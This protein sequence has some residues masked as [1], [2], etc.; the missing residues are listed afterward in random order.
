MKSAP[1]TSFFEGVFALSLPLAV[2]F[3]TFDFWPWTFDP[4]VKESSHTTTQNTASIKFFKCPADALVDTDTMPKYI[5]LVSAAFLTLIAACGDPQN[6]VELEAAADS[7]TFTDALLSVPKKDGVLKNDTLPA[8]YDLSFDEPVYGTLKMK[9]DGSFDYQHDG[10]DTTEDSFS[11]TL[12]AGGVEQSATVTLTKS[13]AEP[14][15]PE[16]PET[17][18]NPDTPSN[19]ETPENPEEPAALCSETAQVGAAYE[20]QLTVGD[21]LKDAP[22]G[23]VLHERSGLLRWT[24]TSDQTKEQEFV[25]VTSDAE[26]NFKLTV[27]AGSENPAGLYVAPDGDDAKAGDAANPFATLQHAVE[28]AEPG[29]TIYVRGGDYYHPEYA[30]P[31]EGRQANVVAKVKKSGEAGKPITLKNYGNEF[32]RII[33]DEGGVLFDKGVQYWVVEGL[34]LQGN[35]G[36][37]DY[38]KRWRCG[39]PTITVLAR[40]VVFATARLRTSRFATTSSMTFPVAAWPTTAQTALRFRTI[41]STIPAGGLPPVRTAS[42]TRS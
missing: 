27:S 13:N 31:F 24:P 30:Q 41:S 35:L 29:Q 11:Y 22:R 8:S 14:V 42:P 15:T 4:N 2:R 18:D 23:M 33:T 25:I 12:T 37:L 39:G 5:L 6:S 9:K 34:E 20:C 10:S 19:P 17:P 36:D 3:E 16:N 21:T 7:Y 1:L 32:A 28:V 38:K 40:A 26:V